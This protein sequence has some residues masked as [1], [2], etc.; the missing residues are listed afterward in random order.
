MDKESLS[1]DKLPEYVF[2]L[3]KDILEL[4][5]LVEE[6]SLLNKEKS[7]IPLSIDQAS[8]IIQKAK[9]TIY[10]LV[11]EGKIP[12]YKRGKQLYFFEEELLEWI[13]KGKKKTESEIID[14]SYQNLKFNI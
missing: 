3:K 8:E 12:C 9:P 2:S 10:T 1:F 13:Q 7:S 5:K 4:K 14:E 11:R 6:S